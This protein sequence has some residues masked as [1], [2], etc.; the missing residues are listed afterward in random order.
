MLFIYTVEAKLFAIDTEDNVILIDD[1]DIRDIILKMVKDV[2][3]SS[4][5][6]D[7][8]NRYTVVLTVEEIYNEEDGICLYIYNIHF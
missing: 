4:E 2:S 7:L 1:E 6:H 3:C 5:A 8:D